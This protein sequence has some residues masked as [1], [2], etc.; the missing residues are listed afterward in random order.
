M[1]FG[2]EIAVWTIADKKAGKWYRGVLDADERFM[3]RFMVRWHKDEADM[4]R[5]RHAS[6]VGGAQ[7]NGKGG[8]NSR[9]VDEIRKETSD[10]VAREQT[11]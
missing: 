3:V 5:K 11:D 8:G 6:T 9:K 4:S 10:R 1:V 7:G 2:V